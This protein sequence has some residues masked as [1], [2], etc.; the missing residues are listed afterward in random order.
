MGRFIQWPIPHSYEN[1]FHQ[2][3]ITY[4]KIFANIIFEYLNAFWGTTCA[5]Q[6]V[7]SGSNWGN[8]SAESKLMLMDFYLRADLNE[9][10]FKCPFPCRHDENVCVCI[11]LFSPT[12]TAMGSLG[13]QTRHHIYDNP[14]YSNSRTHNNEQN[15]YW[16]RDIW[17]N[18]RLAYPILQYQLPRNTRKSVLI[19]AIAL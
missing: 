12:T 17:C 13:R 7:T 15:Q 1:I 14:I 3:V 19:H 16:Y 5:E 2:S 18:I 4:F 8:S 9:V 6:V 11:G 10:G